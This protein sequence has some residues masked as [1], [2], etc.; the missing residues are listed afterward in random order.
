M[1][2]FYKS[3]RVGRNGIP[4]T[5]YKVRTMKESLGSFASEERYTWA[6]RF[7]RKW[8][9]DEVP[10]LWNVLKRDMNI[11]GPRPQEAATIKLYP[12][13]IK[14]RLLSIRPGM[15]GMAGIFFI[16]EEK[17]LAESLDPHKDYWEKIAPMKL[18]LDFFYIENKCLSLDAWIVWQGIKKRI[19]TWRSQ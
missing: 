2:I 13:I 14:D 4:F 3:Y 5:M 11:V 17:V 8:R 7:L 15:F 18:T 1:S 19:K 12:A 16:D 9:L 6:G 10:Q